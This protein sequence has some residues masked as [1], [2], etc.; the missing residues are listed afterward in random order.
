LLSI[1]NKWHL[2]FRHPEYYSTH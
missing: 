2:Y 1:S